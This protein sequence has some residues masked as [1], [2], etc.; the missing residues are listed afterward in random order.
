M[1]LLLLTQHLNQSFTALYAQSVRCGDFF[2]SCYSRSRNNLFELRVRKMVITRNQRLSV[3]QESLVALQVRHPLV[4]PCLLILAKSLPCGKSAVT[5]PRL[6]KTM[7]LVPCTSIIFSIF[8]HLHFYNKWRNEFIE[9]A[10]EWNKPKHEMILIK[11]QVPDL[12]IDAS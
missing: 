9:A 8:Q 1:P 5:S 3:V 4:A 11:R 6:A 2:T 12:D 10:T 7:P